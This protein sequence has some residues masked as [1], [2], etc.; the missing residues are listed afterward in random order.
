MENRY[1]QRTKLFVFLMYTRKPKY[2]RHPLDQLEVSKI[3]STGDLW[4]HFPFTFA[5]L[6]TTIFQLIVFFNH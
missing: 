3:K 6:N 2:F 4:T 5:H 1:L